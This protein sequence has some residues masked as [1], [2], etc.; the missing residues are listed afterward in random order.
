MHFT[1]V[2]DQVGAV[3]AQIEPF[4][5]AANERRLPAVT[6]L[7]DN[8]QRP[9][10]W[11]MGGVILVGCRAVHVCYPVSALTV[12]AKRSLPDEC[13]P[14]SRRRAVRHWCAPET[15]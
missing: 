14:V 1:T 5:R 12:E 7:R 9:L 4:G 8:G 3:R 15:G 11:G 6:L 10:R 2:V 13:F